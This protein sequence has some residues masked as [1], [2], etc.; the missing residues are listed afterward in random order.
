MRASRWSAALVLLLALTVR[1]A[2][3]TYNETVNSEP[4]GSG[5]AQLQLAKAQAMLAGKSPEHT[6]V[7]DYGISYVHVALGLWDGAP[8]FQRLMAFQMIVDGLMAAA[9]W[10]IGLLLGGLTTAGVAGALYALYIPQVILS[11]TPDYDVWATWGLL[12]PTLLALEAR[13]LAGPGQRSVVRAGGAAAVAGATVA[14]AAVVRS[15]VLY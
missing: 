1:G 6:Y 11:A 14:A 3:F 15:S 13:R 9:A 8:S 2:V 4:V 12:T 5:A 10:R 7:E